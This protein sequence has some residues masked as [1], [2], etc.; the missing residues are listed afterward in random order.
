MSAHTLL[1]V[2][3]DP[4]VHELLGAVLRPP[5]WRIDSAYDGLEGFARVEAHAYDLV[6]TD[7]RMP[8]LDG[9]ELLH[10]IREIRPDA[11]VMVMT[12]ESTPAN[13]VRAIR[14]QAFCYFSKPF[15]PSTVADMITQAVNTHHWQD[16]IEVLSASPDWISLR[17]RCKMETADRLMQF[18]REMEMDFPREEREN[19]ASA[20][21]ELLMNA[22]EH[23]GGSDPNKRVQVT[24]VRTTRAILY[25]IQDPG[26]GFSF[27]NIDHA[28]VA[29]PPDEPVRH[30]EI[31]AEKGVRPGGFGIL[32]TRNLVDELVYNEKGNEVLFIKYLK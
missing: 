12:A 31:R 8:G 3:D 21:R 4:A 25:V 28:A 18:V 17:L 6:L 24:Y 5:D 27:D 2:D 30:L 11:K 23:G 14:D 20:F 1:L 13:I 22:I 19:I 7:V 32:L 9:L 16:D 29:N 10:R 15:S 26:K